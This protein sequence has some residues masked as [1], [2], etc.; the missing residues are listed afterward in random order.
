MRQ[1]ACSVCLMALL[2]S[3]P[4]AFRCQEGAAKA[5][6]LP[7]T[8]AQTPPEPAPVPPQLVSPP[9]ST[10][11]IETVVAAGLMSKDADG[12][13]QAEEAL[14]RAQLASI[15]VKTFQLEKRIPKIQ[16]TIPI[17]DVP[18][19]HWAYG[20]IQIVLRTETMGGDRAGVFSPDRTMKR[21]EGFAIFAQA[22]GVFQLDESTVAEVLNPYPDSAAIPTWFRKSIATALNEGFVNLTNSRIEPD[23][24]MTRGDMA[25]ALARYLLLKQPPAYAQPE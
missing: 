6:L 2:W 8:T 20:D 15:L 12:N 21:A 5:E 25:Y 19:S 3:I 18:P 11:P 4:G 24:T 10:D 13:F 16:G 23:K 1:L 22:Y 9:T 17:A 14:T 7:R